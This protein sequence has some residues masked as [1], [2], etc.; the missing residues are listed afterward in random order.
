MLE[1][2]EDNLNT[3]VSNKQNLANFL[4]VANTVRHNLNEKFGKDGGF[5]DPALDDPYEEKAEDW[6]NVKLPDPVY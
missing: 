5:N 2:F 3:N 1:H 4:R 6:S